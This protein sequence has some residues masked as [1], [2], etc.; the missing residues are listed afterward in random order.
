MKLLMRPG[1][2]SR[3]MQEK[4]SIREDIRRLTEGKEKF[5]CE[6]IYGESVSRGNAGD[7]ERQTVRGGSRD[8]RT[9]QI[10]R[11]ADWRWRLEL[12]SL[13]QEYQRCR[14]QE[15]MYIRLQVSLQTLSGQSRS[16]LYALYR[17]RLTW[18]AVEEHMGIKRSKLGRLRRQAVEQ[19]LERVNGTVCPEQEGR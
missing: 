12:A 8:G 18:K 3:L 17:Q 11:R 1:F 5:A 2:Y 15:R 10:L 14:E 13:E 4:Q 9:L 19:V 7:N 16:L 6:Y